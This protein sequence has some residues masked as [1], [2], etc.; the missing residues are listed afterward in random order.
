MEFYNEKFRQLRKQNKLTMK[1][2]CKLA[3][4]GNTC[5]WEW[6][7][8]KRVPSEKK[9]RRLANALGVSVSKISDL[10]PEAA[11]SSASL[12][13]SIDSLS[14]FAKDFTLKR[15]QKIKEAAKIINYLNRELKLTSVITDI[16]VSHIDIAFYIKGADQKHL[17]LTN[18]ILKQMGL[19]FN[20]PDETTLHVK[21][22]QLHS[23][24]K[25][26]QV[27]LWPGF[28]TDL[29]SPMIVLAFMDSERKK[30]AATATIKGRQAEMIP[31]CDEVVKVK[32]LDSN[33]K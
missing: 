21:P 18:R 6:E 5:L 27:G 3:D 16:L 29:M 13:E 14:L 15:E 4:I 31:A 28:P 19:D 26:I 20:Y 8:G 23:D 33:K 22:S 11:V 7:T 25:K 9:A 1:E 10:E 17:I 2:V 30:K 12:G 32:A 24:L